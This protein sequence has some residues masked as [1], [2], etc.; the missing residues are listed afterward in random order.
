M[1]PG[2]RTRGRPVWSSML[3]R[4]T[5]S[6]MT[7][8]SAIAIPYGK[9]G[10]DDPLPRWLD[11]GLRQVGEERQREGDAALPA[12]RGGGAEDHVDLLLRR[13]ENGVQAGSNATAEVEGRTRGGGSRSVEGRYVVGGDE[14]DRGAGVVLEH[15]VG[16]P[17]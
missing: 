14:D 17:G 5:I 7:R 2:F 1:S 13:L 10:E 6:V 16:G 12:D 8:F 15:H 3:F 9:G 11:V 4:Q